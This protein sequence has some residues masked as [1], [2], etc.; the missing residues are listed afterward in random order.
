[1]G[2]RRE[3]AGGL[4]SKPS[5]VDVVEV[6]AESCFGSG[7]RRR[8]AQALA[9][10]WPVIP[11]GVKLSLGSAS[12]I[13]RQQARKLG[14][15]ARELRSPFVTEH[16]AFTS[17]GGRE[18]GHLT[19][20]PLTLTAV[21][22]VAR[23]VN[24]ARRELPDIPLYLENAAWT[25]RWPEDALDEGSFYHEVV[26]RTGCA[27]LLDLGNVYANACNSGV[28]ALQLLLSYPLG[29]VGMIHLAGGSMRHGFYVDTHAHPVPAPVL[30]LLAAALQRCG[31]VPIIIERDA[32]FPRFAETLAEVQAARV[33]LQQVT[34]P[35]RLA[36]AGRGEGSGGTAPSPPFS[37]ESE[38]GQ[39][40]VR[41]RNTEAP[42]RATRHSAT[43][44][45]FQ[46]L[47]TA[48]SELGELLVASHP[49]VTASRLAFD[50]AAIARTRDVLQSKRIDDAL[51]LLSHLEE[52]REALWPLAHAALLATPRSTFG[53]AIADAFRVAE[54]AAGEPEFAVAACRDLLLLQGRFVPDRHGLRPRRG[55]FLGTVKLP[56]GRR[57]WAAKNV[58]TTAP[59]H[60]YVRG[61]ARPLSLFPSPLPKG[62]P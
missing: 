46:A 4:L 41:A 17:A 34:F 30:T 32:R 14:Q 15:L 39:A 56:D 37:R 9:E 47:A 3:L 61:T 29:R 2:W 45:D 35:L 62:K 49:S 12:G 5:A 42:L 51:P 44:A 53:T 24:T 36:E 28:D 26:D 23:N 13:D 43:I 8:E 59:V 20:L 57:L 22:L 54:R 11:H 48:Q 31:P 55:P 25:L 21:D 58:G 18:I 10:V 38:R 6:V 1:M 52:R 33:V 16:I 7:V 50:P 40:V 27:L 60:L 19:P